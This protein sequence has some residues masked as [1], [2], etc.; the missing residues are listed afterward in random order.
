MEAPDPP[1]FTDNESKSNEDGASHL[2]VN[3]FPGTFKCICHETVVA[4]GLSKATDTVRKIKNGHTVEVLEVIPHGEENRIRGRVADGYVSLQ[5]ARGEYRWFIPLERHNFDINERPLGIELG[6][7]GNLVQVKIRSV[8]EGSLGHR[9]GLYPND[10]LHAINGI[11][12]GDHEETFENFYETELPMTLTVDRVLTPANIV[13]AQPSLPWESNSENGKRKPSVEDE[14]PRKKPKMSATLFTVGQRV[15][16]TTNITLPGGENIEKADTGTIIETVVDGSVKAKVIFHS[17]GVMGEVSPVKIEAIQGEDASRY[18]MFVID[19]NTKDYITPGKMDLPDAPGS[20]TVV[21]SHGQE[22][23][24]RAKLTSGVS[25][26]EN[27]EDWHCVQLFMDGDMVDHAFIGEKTLYRS[28]D[29]EIPPIDLNTRDIGEIRVIFKKS[30]TDSLEGVSDTMLAGCKCLYAAAAT[31]EARALVS[32]EETIP[33]WWQSL[34]ERSR[35]KIIAMCSQATEHYGSLTADALNDVKKK[36]SL[37][38]NQ[39]AGLEAIVYG[40][41]KR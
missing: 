28:H 20:G 26:E 16:A 6:R 22:L 1:T 9:L 41:E 34:N 21:V 25:S 40:R 38:D 39:V 23:R 4:A 11:P 14:E 36:F 35:T 37:T 3:L 31:F 17:V 10:I 24:I 30:T 13:Y 32:N 12:C 27:P 15:R 7:C 2:Q 33:I 18:V 5:K 19:A 8:E 29:F